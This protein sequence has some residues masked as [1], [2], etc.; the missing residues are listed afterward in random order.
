MA[1]G[2]P[3]PGSGR[4]QS[5]AQQARAWFRSLVDDPVRRKAFADAI[6]AQLANNQTDAYLKAVEHGYG[7]APQSLTIS[8]DRANPIFAVQFADGDFAPPA[9][10]GLPAEDVP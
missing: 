10:E 2:G 5:G 8:G 6:D 9:A 3:Q 1:R 7:R 4:P